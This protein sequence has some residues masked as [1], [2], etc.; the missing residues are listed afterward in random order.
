MLYISALINKGMERK[1]LDS[2]KWFLSPAIFSIF[3][4]SLVLL[5]FLNG[6]PKIKKRKKERNGAFFTFPSNPNEADMS[7]VLE[8][9][10]MS[11]N[12]SQSQF[13]L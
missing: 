12:S 5:D 4:L 9:V 1:M 10:E 6:A 7:H 8:F 11:K 2:K 13:R 3:L